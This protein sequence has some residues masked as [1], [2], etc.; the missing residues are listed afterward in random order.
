[1]INNIDPS[2]QAVPFF[3]QNKHLP[4][5]EKVQEMRQHATIYPPQAMIFKAFE[6][7]PLT[8]VKVVILGQD[9]YHG[10]EQA[11]G[12]SFSVP[13]HLKTPPSLRN[14]FKEIQ[15]DCFP[16]EIK[17]FQNDLTRW[18]KQGVFLLNTVLTVE[19]SK[20]GSHQKMGWEQLTDDVIRTINE[21]QEHCV[22]MLWGKPAQKKT[23]LLDSSK[24]LVLATSHPSPLGAYRGFNGC[25][26]FSQTNN[27]LSEHNITP[28]NWA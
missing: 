27:F 26:H 11:Q 12:L 28:I 10:P 19:A 9:P 21:S 7:V 23:P 5:L 24:H 14:I 4:L 1:M 22:F 18:A 3:Q 8:A 2:W 25:S 13:N 17:E 20:A 15:R 16:G 6:W